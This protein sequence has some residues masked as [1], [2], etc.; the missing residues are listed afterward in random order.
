M[1]PD[2]DLDRE[3]RVED[4]EHG[5][6]VDRHRPARAFDGVVRWAEVVAGDDQVVGRAA[7]FEER[8]AVG[9]EEA[10]AIGGQG[11]AVVVDAAVDGPER[12]K[13][14]M[15]GGGAALERVVAVADC[16]GPEVVAQGEHGVRLG[17]ERVLRRQ[18]AALL[19]EQQE[20]E[21]HQ[22]RDGRLVDLGRGDA[23]KNCAV[24]GDVVARDRADEQ[25]DRA[26]HRQAETLGDLRLSV[27]GA[28]EQRFEGLVV[29]AP[30]RSGGPRAARRTRPAGCV[31]RRGR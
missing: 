12:G 21:P 4:G 11:E 28:A 3:E 23:A 24:V 29:S 17:P 10:A 14:P 30:R 20:H 16:R 31:R 8:E 6:V 19:G 5:A 18:E 9:V 22:H 27:G 25:L 13:Q 26:A 2:F 1:R 15:P 7:A